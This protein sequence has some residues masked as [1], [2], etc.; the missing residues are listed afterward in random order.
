VAIID[1]GKLLV[2]DTPEALKQQVGPGDIVEVRFTGGTPA[3]AQQIQAALSALASDVSLMHLDNGCGACAE[4][5]CQPAG[6]LDAR[7]AGLQLVR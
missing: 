3:L 4:C 2:M 7:A 5:S 6:Y 1:H